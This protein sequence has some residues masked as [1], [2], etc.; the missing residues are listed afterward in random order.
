MDTM[1]FPFVALT[2]SDSVKIAALKTLAV[3]QVAQRDRVLIES[4]D[5]DIGTH[6]L[7]SEK[8]SKSDAPL[9]PISTAS[10]PVL[11]EKA[12]LG[13]ET[14]ENAS[15][16]KETALES[17]SEPSEPDADKK[18][19]IEQRAKRFTKKPVITIKK[20]S[21]P[22][23][24]KPCEKPTCAK[25]SQSE[26]FAYLDTLTSSEV[27]ELLDSDQLSS[28]TWKA[29]KDSRKAQKPLKRVTLKPTGKPSKEPSSFGKSDI[30]TQEALDHYLHINDESLFEKYDWLEELQEDLR[31]AYTK[32][33]GVNKCQ[34]VWA[35]ACK[36]IKESLGVQCNPRP[37]LEECVLSIEE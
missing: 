8:G 1:T 22:P 19:A 29:W 37:T 5:R 23:Q 6:Y 27:F 34:S 35:N 9:K 16:G 32:K 15:K 28:E 25:D 11:P 13:E 36:S 10:K 18:P 14:P 21:E 33:I 20:E 3:T 24:E 26:I 2:D 4:Y 17:E 7:K 31:A 30:L 12:T